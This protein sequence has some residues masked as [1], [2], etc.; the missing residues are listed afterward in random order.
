MTASIL[1]NE[2]LENLGGADKINLNATLKTDDENDDIAE[3]YAQSN[4]FEIDEIA[5]LCQ[6][7]DQ[8]FFTLSLNIESLKAK[9]N[10]FNVF[11]QCLSDKKCNIDAFLLQETWLT[12]KQ[13]EKENIKMYEI[14]GYHAIPLGKTC[15]RKGGLIIY[16]KD[17]YT[18]TLRDL[19][20]KS[21]HWEGLFV[22]ITHKHNVKLP[23]K[24]NTSRYISST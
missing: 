2:I 10:Q 5:N 4:Y 11:L 16:L 1:A 8:K 21:I 15:G 17:F 6:L 19:Y 23:Q 24:N 14:P 9:F 18:Y 20:S 7:N 22:D 13:C 12:D 3:I